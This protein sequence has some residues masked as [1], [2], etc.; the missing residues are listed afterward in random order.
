MDACLKIGNQLLTGDQLVSAL[1]RYKLMET[2]IGQVVLD[3][4]LQKAQQSQLTQREVFQALTGADG[5]QLP[6]DFE[7]FLD[8][9]CQKQG[10]SPVYVKAVE[11]REL[12]IKKLKKQLFSDQIE[13]EF[14]QR[15]KLL[16][17]VEFSRI[18]LTDSA[19]AEELYFQIRDDGA[20]FALLAQQYSLGFERHSGGRIGPVQYSQ[21]PS[22]IV[23]LFR[24]GKAGDLYAPVQ[25]EESFWLLRLDRVILARL[26]DAL[27]TEL[28]ERLF[29]E[30]LNNQVRSIVSLPNGVQFQGALPQST[31][32][33]L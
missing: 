33:H 6:E 29:V 31:G 20:D 18:Q 9:W 28:V 3:D 2:L 13:A 8:Q 19:L 12:Q 1:V 24:S 7:V 23:T 32:D 27:R 25:V 16:D 14:L 21:L 5:S 26:N 22:H 11:L 30:W 15:K 17:Q 4:V 10:V